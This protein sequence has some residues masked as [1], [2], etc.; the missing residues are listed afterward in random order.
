VANDQLPAELPWR[1]FVRALDRLGYVPLKS[2]RGTARG[3]AHASRQ[4]KSVTFNEPNT[5]GGRIPQRTLKKY[6]EK[7]GVSREEFIALLQR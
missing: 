1:E 4:P 3:F 5:S 2:T 6:I 7:L